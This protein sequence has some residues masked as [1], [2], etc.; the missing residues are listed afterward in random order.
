MRLRG[1]KEL[2]L[3]TDCVL[4]SVANPPVELKITAA[5]ELGFSTAE[6]VGA[7]AVKAGDLF[8]VERWVTPANAS[9]KV[10]L[11]PAAPPDAIHKTLA[12]IARL[13]SDP[14]IQFMSDPTVGQPTNVMS[15]NG[16]SWI[17]ETNPAQGKPVDLGAAPSADAIKK[18]L[19]A[20]A[21]FLFLAP[22]TPEMVAAL[23]PPGSVEIVKKRADSH[24]WLCGRANGNAIE[25][26]WL[27]PDA[28]Q[29]T[30]LQMGSRLPLP[31]RT[32]WIAGSADAAAALNE[33]ARALARIRGWLTLES[34]PSQDSFPY[35]L[36]LRNAAA[37][38]FHTSGDVRDKE[39]YQLY[40]K[41]D[42]AALKS[43]KNL[44]RRW[45]YVFA[46][47]SFGECTLLYPE[48]GRGNE[49]N[50]QPYAMVGEQPKFE[51]Q[52][53][54]PG[55][56]FEIAAPFGVDSYFLLTTEQAVDPSAFTAQ[57][58]RTRAGTRGAAADALSQMLSDVNT[59][60]RAA[61]R[62]ET[63]GTWSIEFQTIR[64]V[65]K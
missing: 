49:G 25:Y 61:K 46:I 30:A 45:V 58:V 1:G 38:E 51:P 13:R 15:W 6:A 56:K 55:A 18:L 27:L 19:P 48:E 60:T 39:K 35:H 14:G 34:P 64:S 26:A 53:E 29:E 40:L 63:P 43:A 24:Y 62:A 47:D 31:L 5:N 52:I 54:L 8:S 21:R 37:S 33:K 20:R 22:P 7:G 9:L 57:G 32:D 36:A 12:E 4:K 28:T 2:G 42:E 65:E 44:A 17:L 50:L 3:Y 59:G 16:A 11:P 41:A 23:H 10:F